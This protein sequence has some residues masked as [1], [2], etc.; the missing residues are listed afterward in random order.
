[1]VGSAK[2]NLYKYDDNSSRGFVLGI[3]P[4]YAAE[5]HNL[6]NDYPLA[7]DKLEIKTKMLS[8]YQ[9]KIADDYNV[10]IGSVKKLVPNFFDKEKYVLH[11]KNLQFYLRLGFKKCPK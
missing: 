5:L 7:P 8:D 10:S 9:L 1:M 3:D 2:F 4:E 11:Y 6:H